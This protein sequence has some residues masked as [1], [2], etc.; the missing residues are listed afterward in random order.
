MAI[1]MQFKPIA[2]AIIKNVESKDPNETIFVV[3]KKIYKAKALLKHF[4]K[5]DAIASEIIRM[6][7]KYNVPTKIIT[8]SPF[9]ITPAVIEQTIKMFEV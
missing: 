3:G 2:E 5:E 1:P 7:I 6:A 4:K 9:D 8:L